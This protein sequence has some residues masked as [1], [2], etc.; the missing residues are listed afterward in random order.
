MVEPCQNQYT[1]SKG[2]H[3]WVSGADKVLHDHTMKKE[4]VFERNSKIMGT[5]VTFYLEDEMFS[6]N[7]QISATELAN[8]GY[9]VF[10]TGNSKWPWI[11]V[12]QVLVEKLE[13]REVCM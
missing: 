6:P 10:R 12:S 11:V 4:M 9:Y 1:V 2:D 7:N 8:V 3:V 13:P 5:G